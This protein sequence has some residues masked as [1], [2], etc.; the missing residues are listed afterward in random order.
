MAKWYLTLSR[1]VDSHVALNVKPLWKYGG[2]RGVSAS[3]ATVP[4]KPQGPQLRQHIWSSTWT[5]PC[6]R[7]G[8]QL[9]GPMAAVVQLS[10][11]RVED[12]VLLPGL[13][14]ASHKCSVIKRPN[15]MKCQPCTTLLV[16]FGIPSLVTAEVGDLS[17][18]GAWNP[19][20]GT[21][22]E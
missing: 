10:L 12:R 13:H 3:K 22:M 7:A 9:L 15:T 1:L 4:G 8:R 11:F 2:H 6:R 14:P 16:T 5:A 19:G 18:W 20:S 17:V 21:C